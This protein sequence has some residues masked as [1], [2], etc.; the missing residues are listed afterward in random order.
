M[1]CNIKIPASRITMLEGQDS[2]CLNASIQIP[3][4]EI[5]YMAQAFFFI[6]KKP[7]ERGFPLWL[8]KEKYTQTPV[9]TQL[10]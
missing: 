3:R 6:Y 8:E 2:K 9:L 5:I 1:P 7:L 10:S 4:A